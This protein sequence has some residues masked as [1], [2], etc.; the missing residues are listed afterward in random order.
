[1]TRSRWGTMALGVLVLATA[2]PFY[3][4]I[5]SSLTPEARLFQSPSLIPTT[6]VLEH[7]R[8]LFI[9][10]D[11]WVPIRNSLIVAGTTTAFC[12]TVGG[13]CAYLNFTS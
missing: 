11:F 2:F 3:W 13:F 5:V 7:Y 8:A 10:R 4:A 12:V 6:L 1:M 9:E